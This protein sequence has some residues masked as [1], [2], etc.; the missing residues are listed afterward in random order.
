MSY[1]LHVRRTA[2]L[3]GAGGLILLGLA[4][5]G[6]SDAGK[7]L[8][9]PSPYGSSPAPS[10]SAPY[11]V[12]PLTGLPARSP[13]NAARPAFG[14]AVS[15][16]GVSGLADA[17]VVYEE[18][19]APVRYLAI[20]QSR[21]AGRIGPLGQGR[22]TDPQVLGMLHG[23]VGYTS[24]RP[25]PLS[26][27]KEMGAVDAG[28]P[29]HAKA[30]HSSGGRTYTSTKAMYAALA[31]A[32][33][34]PAS[35]PTLFSYSSPGKPLAGGKLK[36]AGSLTVSVPGHGTQHWSYTGGVWKRTGGGPRVSAA[37]VVVQ[38]TAYKATNIAKG[39]VTAP[40]AKVFGRGACQVVSGAQTAR[41]HWNR[42]ATDALM[43]YVDVHSFPFRFAPGRTW[44]VLAPPGTTARTAP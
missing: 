8:P 26:Q 17:D 29:G 30:Y 2:A 13:S 35:A 27:F 42:Q 34:K 10:A 9:P 38:H 3:T 12:S 20:Y 36:K 25:G 11:G 1:V 44:V 19:S 5:C 37:N 21:D 14:V 31:K 41:G 40:K 39:G 15:G 16:S 24:I 4:A 43:L 28:L 6:G 32:K 18:E 23:A 7:A 22:S 33:H